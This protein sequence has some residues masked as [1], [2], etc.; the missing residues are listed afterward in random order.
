MR[1]PRTRSS[2]WCP[3]PRTPVTSTCAARVQEVMVGYSDSNKDA[4]ILAS[5]FALYRAQ[6]KLVLLAEQRG[7]HIK[8]FHGRGG[9]IGRG[10]GPALRAV[11]SLPPGAIDG[12]FKLTEQGEV[13]GWKYLLPEI[14]ERNLELHVTAVLHASLE[15]SYPPEPELAA[16]EAAFARASEQSLA[17]YRALTRSEDILTY[18]QGSTPIAEIAQMPIGSRPARRGAARTLDDLRAIPWVFA[19]TQSRQIVPGWF[20]AGRAL[21]S[22]LHEHGV[23]YVRKM[24]KS[25]PFFATTIDAVAV[26]LAT[27]DMDIARHY[28]ALVE[29]SEVG[30]RLFGRIALDHAR[31][32]RAVCAITGQ[33]TLLAHVPALARSIALRNPYV[34]PLSFIQIDLLR[35]K[36]EHAARGEAVPP[37]LERALLLTINGIA[38]G[39]RNTG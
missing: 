15:S 9:S 22:L 5:S 38:A 32:V 1:A 11:E 16:Y 37:D 14:A 28:A 6:K 7:I 26:S 29:P 10:G 36:R 31:A 19:W 39:L 34:D 18:F 3:T 20:G 13:V 33:P 24:H 8:V 30:R 21:Q 12:R 27:A 23:A 4:G 2:A 17:T 25:W 35:R